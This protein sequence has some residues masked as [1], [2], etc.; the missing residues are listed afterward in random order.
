[1]L[2]CRF[3]RAALACEVFILL[4]YEPNILNLK[5]SR[6]IQSVNC[7]ILNTK[8]VGLSPRSWTYLFNFSYNLLLKFFLNVF[9][10]FKYFKKF[11]VK[12]INCGSFVYLN[13]S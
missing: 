10:L 9:I 7:L 6:I 5:C 1:M 12:L 4:K 8:N 13:C 11:H 3:P 2:K